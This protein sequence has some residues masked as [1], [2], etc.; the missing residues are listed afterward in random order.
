[1]LA[2]CLKKT[3]SSSS[4]CNSNDDCPACQECVSKKCKVDKDSICCGNDECQP[5]QEN[6]CTCPRD[7]G[8]CESSDE[9]LRKECVDDTCA[10]TINLDGVRK[11]SQAMNT[12][13]GS[14]EIS[15]IPS[16]DDPFILG[17]SKFNIRIKADKL[18][19]KTE[20]DIKRIKIYEKESKS[21]KVL[22]A[23]RD[24][25]QKIYTINT[26]ISEDFVL[27]IE[28]GNIETGETLKETKDLEIEVIYDKNQIN[29]KGKLVSSTGDFAKDVS[30][31]DFVIPPTTECNKEECTDD[32]K[33]TN[34]ACTQ[35]NGYNYCMHEYITK[36]ICCGN[37]VCEQGEDKCNCPF[38]CGDCEYDYGEFIHYRCNSDMECVPTID[39][40]EQEEITKVFNPSVGPFK[41]RAEVIYKQPFNIEDSLTLELMLLQIDDNVV[42]NEILSIELIDS[43]VDLLGE[44]EFDDERFMDVGDTV[45]YDIEPS[46][47]ETMS[48]SERALNPGVVMSFRYTIQTGDKEKEYL[49]SENL[50]IERVY[51]VKLD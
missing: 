5:H 19:D 13:I 6:E 8:K 35:L 51:F 45:V 31:V 29:Y 20:L 37:K 50:N 33:C 46:N 10:S 9:Y 41:F 26:E 43:G 12:K 28:R 16:F 42:L 47:L 22:L 38:D 34:D 40:S 24:L 36:R 23:E 7:C 25:G 32:N 49:K 21:R 17:H 39:E 27:E 11:K 2:G 14:S 44:L 30:D 18:E 15:F 3:S 4:G 1:M 48:D